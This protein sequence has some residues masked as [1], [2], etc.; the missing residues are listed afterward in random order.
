MLLMLLLLTPMV[1]GEKRG[2]ITCTAVTTRSRT[3]VTCYFGQDISQSKRGFNVRFY[4]PDQSTFKYT[5]LMCNFLQNGGLLCQN[6][7]DVIFNR[8]VSDQIQFTS[9]AAVDKVGGQY[10]CQV[11]PHPP[12]T[13]IVP[14][15]LTHTDAY[16]EIPMSSPPATTPAT[17]VILTYI[18]TNIALTT[19]VVVFLVLL[20]VALIFAVLFKLCQHR[21]LTNAAKLKNIQFRRKP[22]QETHAMEEGV[23]LDETDDFLTPVQALKKKY[24]VR[25]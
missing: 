15:N 16:R 19:V 21:I 1:A 17:N 8:M 18:Q 5:P 3:E 13:D 12:N 22:D 23:G 7:S 25:G 10:V 4:Y 2:A 6:G 9:P 24:Q 11:D 14:C 20:S